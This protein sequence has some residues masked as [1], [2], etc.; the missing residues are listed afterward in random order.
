M[1]LYFSCFPFFIRGKKAVQS[2]REDSQKTKPPSFCRITF[3]DMAA[4]IIWVLSLTEAM[5]EIQQHKVSSFSQHMVNAHLASLNHLFETHNIG[6]EVITEFIQPLE[7]HLYYL[8]LVGQPD[9]CL[10]TVTFH[11]PQ[12]GHCKLTEYARGHQPHQSGYGIKYD[13][14][15]P[16]FHSGQHV[17]KIAHDKQ[18]HEHKPHH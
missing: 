14:C 15:E 2:L 11:V 12:E 3:A 10:F 17:P 1:P 8:H 4:P 9:K 18:S 6:Y 13:H 7:G 16:H 5:S